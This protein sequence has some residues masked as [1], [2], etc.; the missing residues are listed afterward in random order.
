MI[1]KIEHKLSYSYSAPVGLN[2]HYLFL[3]PKPTPYQKVLSQELLIEPKPAQ[4]VKNFDQ[5]DNI[6]HICFFNAQQDAFIVE[7][8]FVIDSQVFSPLSF[9]FYPFEAANIPITYKSKLG[10]YASYYLGQ[11]E[12][13]SEVK[14]FALAIAEGTHF[15]TL[16]FLMELIKQIRSQFSYVSRETGNANSSYQTL[17]TLQG[18]CRDFAVFMMD[19]CA[20][21]GMVSRFVS[22][23]LYGS[24]LHQH[25]LHAWVEVLLPGGGWRGFD[26]TEGRVV[27]E[28]YIALASSVEPMGLNP[29]RGTYR[30][31]QAVSSILEASVRITPI[32]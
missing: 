16:N 18:S 6:Q 15:V 23:Y 12:I 25:E 10:M 22:G 32:G 7:S 5:E 26:P 21:V 2:P 27:N 29:V 31:A 17:Q 1:L 13:S 9:I 3:S 11:R 30:S 19:A 4:L 8:V 28:N 24:E 14:A 20:A